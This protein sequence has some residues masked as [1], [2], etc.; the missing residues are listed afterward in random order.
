MTTKEIADQLVALCRAGRNIEAVDTLLSA[1]VVSVEARGDE[2]MP[3]QMSGRDVIRGKNQ[4]WLDNHKIHS[5]EV[6][7]PFP[8]GDRFAVIYNF[9][10]TP[11]VGP[12]AGKKMRMEEVALYTVADGKV[13]R[14][15]FFYDMSGGGEAAAKPKP[16]ARKKAKKVVAKKKAAAK[17]GGKGKARTARRK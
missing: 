15:E 16:K 3:A 6:K 14:E 4:W 7:G 2:T 11:V 17:A 10:V 1:D 8:N 12:M 13:T 9:V 5:A